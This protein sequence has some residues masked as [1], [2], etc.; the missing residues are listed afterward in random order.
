MKQTIKEIGTINLESAELAAGTIEMHIPIEVIS[1]QMNATIDNAFNNYCKS[2]PQ[3]NPETV[4]YDAR[5]VFQFG[6]LNPEFSLMLIIFDKEDKGL[7]DFY[8]ELEVTLSENEK[9]LF[10]KIVLNKLGELFNSNRELNMDDEKMTISIGTIDFSDI[11]IFDEELDFMEVFIPI[12]EV[13]ESL[14]ETINKK[15]EEEK[16]KWQKEFLDSKG[17]SWGKSGV[18]MEYQALHIIIE[19]DVFSYELC[20]DFEDVENEL[21]TGDFKLEIDLS[22]YTEEFKKI[23]QEARVNQ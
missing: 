7:T 9:K 4:R 2:N 3:V 21:L 11:E 17:M 16:E 20:F 19:K 6:R 23:I 15:V 1:E 14:N 5:L 22:E 18:S 8:D 13:A 12:T 10:K